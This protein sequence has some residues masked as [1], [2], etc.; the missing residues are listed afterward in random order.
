M[1]FMK[2]SRN[3]FTVRIL[4]LKIKLCNFLLLKMAKQKCKF[5]DKMKANHPCFQKGRNEWEAE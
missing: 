1:H 2:S 5:I 4:V 3:V